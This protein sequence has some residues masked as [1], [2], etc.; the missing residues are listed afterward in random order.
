MILEGTC[1][2]LSLNGATTNSSSCRN[3]RSY[4]RLYPRLWTHAA[5]LKFDPQRRR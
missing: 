5:A 4:S 3:G 1:F 2:A